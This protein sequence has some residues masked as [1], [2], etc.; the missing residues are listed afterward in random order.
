MAVLKYLHDNGTTPA[1]ELRKAVKVTY[2]IMQKL[3]RH[4]LIYNF[5]TENEFNDKYL[6]YELSN[7]GAMLFFD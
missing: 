4:G 6:R 2:K 1:L 5:Y 3:N 7:L